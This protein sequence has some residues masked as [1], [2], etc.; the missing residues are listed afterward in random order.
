MDAELDRWNEIIYFLQGTCDS[1][2]RALHI[3]DSE[4]LID[5]MPF[6]E[7]LDQHIFLCDDCGWWCEISE[8]SDEGR[9]YDC[10]SDEY[11]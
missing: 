2:D 7:Y 5:H 1:L 6:L 11:E 8:Q 3:H 9:C 4:D 10:C